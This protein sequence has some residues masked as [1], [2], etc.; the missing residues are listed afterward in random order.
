M[1]VAQSHIWLHKLTRLFPVLTCCHKDLFCCKILSQNSSSW[2]SKQRLTCHSG[3]PDSN[4]SS[5]NDSLSNLGQGVNLGRIY[6]LCL[7]TTTAAAATKMHTLNTKRG[8]SQTRILL[9]E[10]II[11]VPITKLLEWSGIDNEWERVCVSDSDRGFFFCF[12]VFLF[13]TQETEGWYRT[14]FFKERK[15]LKSS[16]S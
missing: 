12:R 9:R 1:T 13:T 3:K 4:P 2:S 15:V 5:A 10:C 8:W 16:R 6:A 7:S 14:I 11:Y